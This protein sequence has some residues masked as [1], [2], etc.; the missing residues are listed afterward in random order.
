MV[1]ALE[2]E[3]WRQHKWPPQPT[4]HFPRSFCTITIMEEGVAAAYCRIPPMLPLTQ[5]SSW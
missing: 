5:L 1:A 3:E 2:A 4:F